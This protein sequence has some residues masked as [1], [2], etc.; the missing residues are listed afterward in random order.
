VVSQYSDGNI[1]P[2]LSF[3]LATFKEVIIYR[4]MPLNSRYII[5]ESPQ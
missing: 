4:I 3:T 5:E 2:A 1:C